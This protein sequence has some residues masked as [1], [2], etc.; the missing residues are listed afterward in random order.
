PRALFQL[1]PD[2]VILG[3]NEGLNYIDR[4]NW[5][6][7]PQRKGKVQRV[8]VSP[9]SGSAE[10]ALAQWQENDVA[11]VI[12]LFGGIGGENKEATPGG[13]V[14][15]HFAYGLA[16][17]VR[18]PITQELQ[19]N[20]LYQQIYSHNTG[21]IVSG[22]HN[23]ES[24]NGNMQRGWL[25]MRPVSDVVVKLDSF[26]RPFQ[27]GETRVSLF[28]ELLSQAQILAARY[29]TGD[30]TGVAAITPA[31]SCVQDSNQALYIAIEQIKQQIDN[32]PDIV[33]WLKDNPDSP[34]V[35]RI[36]QFGAVGEAL[37]EMLTPYGAVRPDWRNNAESLAGIGE[38]QG[39]ESP[40]GLV[41]GLASGI[42]SW[43]TMM[44]RWGHDEVARVF[45]EN[46]AQLWF[47]RT[48]MVG[49]NDPRIEPIPPTTLFGL[50][51]GLGRGVQRFTDA[52][53]TWPTWGMVGI[54]ALALGLYTLVALPWGLRN[55]FLIGQIAFD[56]PI[57]AALRTVRLFF[58]PA[59]VEETIFRVLLLPHPVEGVPGAQW[60]FWAVV[61]TGLFV[62]F[63]WVLGQTLRR[64]MQ[65][66]LCDRRFLTLAGLLGLV[67]A[68]LYRI[69]G[70]LWLIADIHWIVVVFW[71]YGLGGRDR[72]PQG[73]SDP[74]LGRLA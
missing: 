45:L 48:N 5:G 72:L 57:K 59:L 10:T 71:L 65:D 23:W 32:N 55:R 13:T 19:F 46:G 64:T 17:V 9:T 50:V 34:E 6:N 3:L 25:G 49:G 43:R 20:I 74:R 29:R 18:E 36:R 26:T 53:V 44:P 30:G 62:L 37:E 16:Q 58:I 41:T 22:T 28:G 73:K 54:G 24:Y 61:S 63:H 8:L 11:L 27:F 66:T 33:Q 1:E 47:L 40:A 15:G 35:G 68:I 12:H 60:L 39:F 51:P 69:T 42:L 4:Q 70:S 52:V 14:T 21:G 7:S 67:L 38:A 31:S 56:H 2:E